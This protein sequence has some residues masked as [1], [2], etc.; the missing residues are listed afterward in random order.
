MSEP[1]NRHEYLIATYVQHHK[2]SL[3]D[4]QNS[5]QTEIDNYDPNVR[6]PARRGARLAAAVKRYK[7]SEMIGWMLRM[8]KAE[9]LDMTPNLFNK[10]AKEL[11]NRTG[12][13]H[14]VQK[15]LNQSGRTAKSL[16]NNDEIVRYVSN[17]HYNEAGAFWELINDEIDIVK[18]EYQ[19]KINALQK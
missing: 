14:L 9:N 4:L 7:T 18:Y 3:E 6:E 15:I 1:L 8:S 13:N 2:F 5:F 10:I 12:N 19:K 16:T 17:K 11:F